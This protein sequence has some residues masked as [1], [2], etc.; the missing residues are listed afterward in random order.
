MIDWS[1]L[2][3]NWRDLPMRTVGIYFLVDESTPQYIGQSVCLKTR[4]AAHNS[5]RTEVQTGKWSVHFHQCPKH[6]LDRLEKELIRHYHPTRNKQH[7]QH[8]INLVN[9]RHGLGL[10]FPD[11]APLSINEFFFFLEERRAAGESFASIGTSL[12]VTGT[13]VYHWLTLQRNVKKPVLILAAHLAAHL[14]QQPLSVGAGAP[15]P[16]AD[17]G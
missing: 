15:R 5:Y 12:G 16:D 3:S 17:A 10:P 6:D 4:L 11:L 1:V 13:S 14:A 9:V 8:S 2:P 7:R